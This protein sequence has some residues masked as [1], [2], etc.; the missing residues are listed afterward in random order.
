MIALRSMIGEPA[1]G[2][3][4]ARI[5][6]A[7]GRLKIINRRPVPGTHH[8]TRTAR[9]TGSSIE[10]AEHRT[11][12]PGDDP[13]LLDWTAYG[14]FDRLYTRL[15]H[16]EE[17]LHVCLLLDVSR[18]M[19][20]ALSPGVDKFAVA[21]RLAAVLAHVALAGQLQVSLGF[22]A[23]SLVQFSEPLRGKNR[24]HRILALLDAP[25]AGGTGTSFASALSGVA[26]ASPRRSLVVVI[27]DFFDPS[28]IEIPLRKLLHRR[29]DI[30]LV[31]IYETFDAGAFP[32]GD[33]LVVDSE[34]AMEVAI[35]GGTDT[36]TRLASKIAH[37]T[38]SMQCWAGQSG[39]PFARV[40]AN[41]GEDA[42]V[43]SLISA[44][45]LRQ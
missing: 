11:Y 8:A 36:I 20:T 19:Q 13:R 24:F 16:D 40:C 28:G 21:R 31:D 42:A 35:D 41:A 22:F 43:R 32:S 23:E 25:P 39:I 9:R 15:F 26:A 34:T 3:F 1:Y 29:C 6:R 17:D 10:F 30:A 7:L 38:E 45:V 18:S 44:G 27:S 5:L 33:L 12:V 14:R 37:R 2:W 4:D